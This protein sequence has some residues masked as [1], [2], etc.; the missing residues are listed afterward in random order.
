M[1]HVDIYTDGACKGNPGPG[2]WAAILLCNQHSK[3]ISGCDPDTTN[4]KMELQA[5]IRGLAALNRPCEVTIYT[6]SQYIANAI[7]LGWLNHWKSSG[8]HT[9]SG[10]RVK[11]VGYWKNLLKF[12]DIHQVEF[13]WVKGHA[14]N[15][16]N[17][18]CDAIAVAES[19]KA[20]AAQQSS[21]PTDF[22]NLL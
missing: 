19:Q 13:V 2:G 17:E 11:N 20:A 12:L 7:N 16:Y 3:T 5:V 21:L 8:W 10:K 9:A 22:S 14:G 15:V 1:T 4:N 6:D 18:Q